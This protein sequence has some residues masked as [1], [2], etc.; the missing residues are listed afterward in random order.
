MYI[1]HMYQLVSFNIT[2]HKSNAHDHAYIYFI[3]KQ[4]FINA[5]YLLL[6]HVIHFLQENTKTSNNFSLLAKVDP[7]SKLLVQTFRGNYSI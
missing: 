3:E 2:T 4:C 6:S 1:I 7:F 5:N